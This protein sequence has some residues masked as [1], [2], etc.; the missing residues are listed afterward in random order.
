ML[1]SRMGGTSTISAFFTFRRSLVHQSLPVR[2]A[3]PISAM[4]AIGRMLAPDMGFGSG[5]TCELQ[6]EI[7]A[8]SRATPPPYPSRT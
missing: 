6:H 5:V 7:C 1:P 8:R 3:R 2:A 4:H